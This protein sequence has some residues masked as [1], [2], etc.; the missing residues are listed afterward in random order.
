MPTALKPSVEEIR[1]ASPFLPFRRVL[2]LP[3][4]G[5][6]ALL[7][8]AA[9]RI[10][11][12]EDAVPWAFAPERPLTVIDLRRGAEI[13]HRCPGG[14]PGDLEVLRMP[15]HDPHFA[16]LPWAEH[17]RG[18]FRRHYRKLAHRVR[19]QAD[20]ALDALA[21]GRDVLITCQLGRDRT[22]IVVASVLAQLGAAP[23]AARDDGDLTFRELALAPAWLS[24]VLA[25]RGE[26]LD[27]FLLRNAEAR[28]AFRDLF[29]GDTPAGFRAARRRAFSASR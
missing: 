15:L 24:R 4:P 21:A 11:A 28:A 2:A 6:P 1:A 27:G 13:W 10:A 8:A 29:D 23:A 7:R 12:T 3:G 16:A 25:E 20:A 26:T 22:G 5:E 9:G 14:S 18:T 17:T 19:H